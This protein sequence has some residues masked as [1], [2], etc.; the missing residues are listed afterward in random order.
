LLLDGNR[1]L[2]MSTTFSG[3]GVQP[4]GIAEPA[5]DSTFAPWE[6][7][8]SLRLVDL[9][10]PAKPTVIDAASVDGSVLGARLVGGIARVVVRSDAALPYVGPTGGSSEDFATATARNREIIVRS[11]L[12]DW[13]PQLHDAADGTGSTQPL[14]DCADVSTPPE[15]AGLGFSSILTVD[16]DGT[17]SAPAAAGVLAGSDLIYASPTTLYLTSTRWDTW[18][19]SD[20]AADPMRTDLHAFD[21]TDPTGARF[22]GS[23]QVVGHLLNQ[24]S[25]SEHEGVLRVASTTDPM[26]WDESSPPGESRVTTLRLTSGALSQVG[27]LTGLG[28]DERI[29]GVRFLGDTG[30]VVTFRQVDPLHVIDLSDPERPAVAGEL[31]MP[32][33]SAYLHPV[34]D[35]LLLGVG[36]DADADGRRTGLQLSLF[37]VSD[38]AAPTRL[39][40]VSL[41]GGYSDVEYDHL[42]FLWWPA[43]ERAVLPVGQYLIN[44]STGETISEFVGAVGYSVDPVPGIDEV[45]RATHVD[46]EPTAPEDFRWPGIIRNLVVDGR[47]LT[48]SDVGLESASLDTLTEQAWLG[49]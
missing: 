49:F 31:Q 34:G 17:L 9:T 16:L 35:G 22:L 3:G 46:H 40:H 18:L 21:I 2:V 20:R 38:P 14:L 12:A 15:F 39:S 47:L 24:F 36:A 1:L 6:P 5:V 28:V 45:G 10:N 33:Y 13:V 7:L 25:L 19:P 8:T 37:D 29:F 23:G 32:G 30:Y 44:E 4:P 48:L 41:P 42:G 27:L 26:W 43:T 11:T